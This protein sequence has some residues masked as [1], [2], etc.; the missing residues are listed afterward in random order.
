MGCAELLDKIKELMGSEKSG[1]AGPKGLV[2]RF[3]R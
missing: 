3:S 2:P 1:R